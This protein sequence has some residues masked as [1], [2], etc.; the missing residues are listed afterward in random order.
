MAIGVMRLKGASI[1][2]QICPYHP[3]ILMYM[4]AEGLLK[5]AKIYD[6]Q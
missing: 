3:T 2:V 4:T 5:I 1:S 6:F